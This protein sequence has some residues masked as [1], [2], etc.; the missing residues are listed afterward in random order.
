VRTRPA[1]LI[2]VGD[3]PAQKGYVDFST[4]KLIA[5]GAAWNVA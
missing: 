1:G 5:R 3:E 2:Y 4:R